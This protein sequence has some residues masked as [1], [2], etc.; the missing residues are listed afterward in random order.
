MPG[1]SVR[2]RASVALSTTS[3]QEPIQEP[4]LDAPWADGPVPDGPVLDFGGP[5]DPSSPATHVADGAE[6]PQGDTLGS[7]DNSEPQKPGGSE[8]GLF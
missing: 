3:V 7:L 6:T 8:W 5:L 2:A 4:P 1:F